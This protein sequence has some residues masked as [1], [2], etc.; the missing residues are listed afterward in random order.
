MISI[1]Q[2]RSPM[3]DV[4]KVIVLEESPLNFQVYSRRKLDHDEML[5]AV[6]LW[7]ERRRD[8]DELRNLREDCEAGMNLDGARLALAEL[9]EMEK[10]DGLRSLF[11]EMQR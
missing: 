8:H 4:G 3:L 1:M 10:F 11:R 2:F 7:Y 9:R 5:A 6:A